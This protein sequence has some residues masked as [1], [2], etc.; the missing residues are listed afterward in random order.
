MKDHSSIFPIEKMCKTLKVSR[1]AYYSWK[2]RKPTP[3]DIEND[4]L[5]AKIRKIFFESRRT[6]G[7][8]RITIALRRLGIRVSKNRVARIMREEN[9]RS[10]I[11]K[12]FV[13][14]TDSKH[15]YPVVGNLLKR[16]FMV[17]GTGKVW[18]SDLTYIRT[19]Q[20]WLYLTVI[21]DLGDR[22]VVGWSLSTSLKAVD[23]VIP[24]WIMAVKNRPI[25]QELI[26]HSDRGV[27]YACNEFRNLLTG[28]S[29]VKRSMSRKGDCWDNAVVESFF[30]NLKMECVYQEKYRSKAQAAL[31][32]FEYIET[33]YNSGRIHTTLEMSIKEYKEE[34]INKKQVA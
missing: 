33:W 19:A 8:P 7:S 30:N 12:K 5:T 20:G 25:T 14:T 31:S 10:I 24:A 17:N 29:L 6:Y 18:V 32:I 22:K 26:F 34:I 27:Q 23:T 1:S 9:L 16:N 21:L 28:Y 15:N 11:R 13:V 2:K 3:R 4:F